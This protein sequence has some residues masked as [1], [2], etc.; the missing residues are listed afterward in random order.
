MAKDRSGVRVGRLVFK[1]SSEEKTSDGSFKWWLTCDCGAEILRDP[2]RVM[3]GQIKSCGCLHK[4]KTKE[5]L[6]LRNTKHGHAPRGKVSSTYRRWQYIFDR[7]KYDPDY[8]SV[9]V[10]S[11]WLSFE[12]FLQD[13]GECPPGLSL[14]RLDNAKGYEPGNCRWAT[15]LV[16]Q[17]NRTNNVVLTY[18]G[19][20]QSLSMWC[21]ELGLPYETTRRKYH[22]LGALSDFFDKN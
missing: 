1:C 12:N 3:H 13:M 22:K 8:A 18:Q 4:E 15:I 2:A 5:R 9:T 7:L 20:S 11:R 16:Q 6:L 19:R 14:D 21:R 17:N 10:S